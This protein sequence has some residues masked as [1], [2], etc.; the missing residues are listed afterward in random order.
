MVFLEYMFKELDWAI[1]GINIDGEYLSR[2]WL[3]GY[4]VITFESLNLAHQMI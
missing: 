3:T 1:K 4:T 2:L